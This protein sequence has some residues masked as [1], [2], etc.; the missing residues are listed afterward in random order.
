M[1]HAGPSNSETHIEFSTSERGKPIL[2]HAGHR[3]NYVQKNK[4][5]NTN[6]R[7]SNK[8]ECSSSITIDQQNRIVKEARHMCNPDEIRNRVD[9]IKDQCKKKVCESLEPVPKLFEDYMDTVDC[10]LDDE[11]KPTFPH[12]KDILYRARQ[13]Y[14]NMNT[15]SCKNLK[16]LK[17][18]HNLVGDFFLYDEGIKNKIIIFGTPLAKEH[19]TKFKMFYGDGTFKIC[20]T[21]FYQLYTFHINISLDENSVNFVPVL[22]IL[23]ANK[24]QAIYERLFTILKEQFMIQIDQYKCDFELA[25][26]QAV[27]KVYPNVKVTGC[28]FH[29]W[30]ALVKMS[31]KLGFENLKDGK[32]IT[33]L[34]MQLPLLP[35]ILIP[36]AILGIQE[37]ANDSAE[38]TAFSKYFSTQWMGIYTENVFACYRENFRTNNPVEGWHGRLKKRFPIKPPLYLFLE[39]LIKESRFQD[40][41]LNKNLIYCKGKRRDPKLLE[42]NKQIDTIVEA[43]VKDEISVKEC[44]KRLCKINCIFKKK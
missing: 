32:H 38:Y 44:L 35:P 1:D 21:P 39:L 41:K 3:Y 12:V 13:D 40:R 7:C 20:P 42:K 10:N 15:N 18:P 26:I 8:Q 34:Y 5:G 17:L 19:L 11:D 43:T 14:L 31:K 23:L 33:Q 37:K 6:W 24:T 9:C 25:V 28:Y 16:Q 29:Y 4:S 36:E 27:K 2:L 30:K 22:Y